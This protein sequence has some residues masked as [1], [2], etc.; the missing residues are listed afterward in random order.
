SE[1]DSVRR[2]C[3]LRNVRVIEFSRRRLRRRER[4]EDH[5]LASTACVII[6]QIEQSA[7]IDGGVTVRV[8]RI[9][10]EGFRATGQ[11]EGAAAHR[12]IYRRERKRARAGVERYWRRQ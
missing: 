7:R 10:G 1:I 11:A 3:H 9:A 5:P 12:P 4:R 2:P 6:D 8:Y